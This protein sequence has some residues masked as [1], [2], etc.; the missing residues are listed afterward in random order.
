MKLSSLLCLALLPLLLLQT[1]A[2]TFG[3]S[4]I[5]VDGSGLPVV[6]SRQLG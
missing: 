1:H 2:E 4:V 5:L 6:A 3:A